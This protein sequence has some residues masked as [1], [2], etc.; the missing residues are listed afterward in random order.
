MTSIGQTSAKSQSSDP[1]KPLSSSFA[2]A[3]MVLGSLTTLFI[4]L[5]PSIFCFLPQCLDVFLVLLKNIFLTL[6][7]YG[8]A[9]SYR[10]QVT[11]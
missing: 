7:S 1:L 4:P 6:L 9:S 2:L 8:L 5:L 3:K 11:S 10:A